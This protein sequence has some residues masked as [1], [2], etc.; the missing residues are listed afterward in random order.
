MFS[1][2]AIDKSGTIYVGNSGNFL[3][4]VGKN[5]KEK[6]KFR[7]GGAI[8][9]SPNIGPDGTVYIGSWDGKLYAISSTGVPKWTYQTG[10]SIV[11]SSPAI[12]E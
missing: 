3:F 1:T 5:M 8:L 10:D 11:L 7:T 9:S 2:P 6:W 12:S 4:A